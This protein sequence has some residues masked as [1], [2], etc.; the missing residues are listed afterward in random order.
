[1]FKKHM[2]KNPLATVVTL[3][4]AMFLMPFAAQLGGQSALAGT[5]DDTE[6]ARAVTAELTEETGVRSDDIQVAYADGIVRLEGVVDSLADKRQAVAVATTIRGVRAVVDQLS[7]R[8]S[9][10]DVDQITGRITEELRDNPVTDTWQIVVG[11]DEGVV[12]LRGHVDSYV[13]KMLGEQMV[14]DIGGVREIVND[15]VVEQV[16]ERSSDEIQLEIE[17][18]IQGDLWLIDPDIR[19]TVD[20]GQVT[21]TGTVETEAAKQ[22]L[23]S[24]AWVAGVTFVEDAAVRVD[25]EADI[26][27]RRHRPYVPGNDH[28]ILLAVESALQY[29][30]RVDASQVHVHVESGVVTLGGTVD[31]LRSKRAAEQDARNTLG[32]W[33][34]KNAILVHSDHRRSAAAVEQSLGAALARDRYLSEYDLT[35]AVEEGR[36]TLRGRVRSKFD[37]RRA[38][39]VASGIR[40][41]SEVQNDLM[42]RAAVPE[43]GS[44]LNLKYRIENRLYWSPLIDDSEV[45]VTVSGGR[46]TL[47]GIVDSPNALEIAALIARQ[48]GAQQVN[49]QITIRET[50]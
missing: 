17:K 3:T 11:V 39:S 47:T 27:L 25:S 18:R 26:A 5:I 33:D 23:H 45:S 6:I 35:V 46:V 41:V 2:F 4:L 9:D 28:E 8:P 20:D 49:S 44:D 38:E 24:L 14:A 7:L 21:L 31:S 16:A 50:P 19:V 40:G 22:R 15:L 48:A 43:P 36:A 10:P 12:T 34:V 29:D 37:K 42:V 13:A 32:V 1:M 30:P